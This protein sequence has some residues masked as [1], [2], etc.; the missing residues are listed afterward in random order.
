MRILTS[1]LLIIGA[2]VCGAVLRFTNLNWDDGGRL[3]PDEA[4]IVNGALVIKFFSGLFPGF[5]DYN[6]FSVYLLAIISRLITLLSGSAYWS[7]TPEGL[8]LTGRFL[9]ALIATLSIPL[10]FTVG[11]QLWNTTVGVYAA[12]LLTLTPL[13]IQLAHFYTT[14]NI[15]IFLFL[16]L[17]SSCVSYSKYPGVPRIVFMALVLGLLLATKNTAYLLIPI[18]LLI[19]LAGHRP[20]LS[21][22]RP[23]LLFALF[24]VAAFFTGS[25]Y[26]FLDASGY[27]TR[28]RYLTDVVNGTLLMDWTM[29]F[30]GTNG[31]FWIPSLLY[32]MGVIFV[33]GAIGVISAIYNHRMNKSVPVFLALWSL[34]FMLF[35]AFTYL[36]FTRYSAPLIP[37]FALFSAKLLTDLTRHTMGKTIAAIVI[38]IQVIYGIMFFP[39]Y[40]TPH[41]S[42]TAT[43]WINDNVPPSS[44]ILTEE[45]NSIIR[46]SRPELSNKNYKIISFNFYTPDT[47]TKQKNLNTIL[48]QSDYILLESPKVQNTVTRLIETYP[49]TAVFYKKL[50]NGELPFT[51]VIRFTSFPRMGPFFVSDENAEETFTVFD[52]PTI[53]VYKKNGK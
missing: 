36:K 51:K 48:Q 2:I 13:A 14:E 22:W 52:H 42:L 18:P 47:D 11:K 26:S 32:A 24:T 10:V 25:P 31:L 23:L 28:S 27:I 43:R 34:G 15:I 4:L 35:L 5:H 8:T 53:T 9:S 39:V 3:H 50:E 40:S 17:I 44:V 19:I 37:L 33:T 46:F 16:L 30:Q 49:N 29:Q 12:I 41:T 1:R 21:A 7:Q 45:W 38:G 20:V 6:G